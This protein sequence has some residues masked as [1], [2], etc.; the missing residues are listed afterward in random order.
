MVVVQRVRQLWITGGL[1][2]YGPRLSFLC[3]AANHGN[4]R[5]WRLTARG[6]GD[7]WDDSAQHMTCGDT[8]F[9]RASSYLSWPSSQEIYHVFPLQI[10]DT[11]TWGLKSSPR[12]KFVVGFCHLRLLDGFVIQND[13]LSANFQGSFAAATIAAACGKLTVVMFC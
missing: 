11:T 13:A 3:S 1:R 2:I 8:R 5:R 6:S 4:P 10:I 9:S 7:L 12:S